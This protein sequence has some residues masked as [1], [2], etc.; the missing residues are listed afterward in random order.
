MWTW[1]T[2][3]TTST[4]ILGDTSTETRRRS[5]VLKERLALN[6]LTWKIWLAPNNASRW[7]I[8]FNSAFKGLI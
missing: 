6:L 2:N 3:P 5:V 1:T 8:R 4:D 7:K